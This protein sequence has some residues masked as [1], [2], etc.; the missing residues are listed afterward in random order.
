MKGVGPLKMVASP[1]PLLGAPAFHGA[2]LTIDYPKKETIIRESSYDITRLPHHP[3]DLLLTPEWVDG[4][5]PILKGVLA[6]RPARFVLDSGCGGIVISTRFARQFPTSSFG[7]ATT[8]NINDVQV[9][10]RCLKLVSGIVAGTH[11]Q[12]NHVQVIDLPGDF[13][14]LIGTDF[15]GLS[16][17]T[18]DY[19]RRKVLLKPYSGGRR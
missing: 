4:Y 15:P 3:H 9:N 18:I 14:A 6:G 2:V 11:F 19:P 7:K 12:A 16:R 8:A 13:D 5:L 17:V 10:I 1:K